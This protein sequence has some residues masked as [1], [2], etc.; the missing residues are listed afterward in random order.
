M[1]LKHCMNLWLEVPQGMSHQGKLPSCQVWYFAK[2]DVMFFACHATSQDHVIKALNDFMIRSPLSY[3]T[4]LL[5][6]VAF[7]TLVVELL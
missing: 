1:C 2:G 4:I 6:L 7:T 3:I 5:S